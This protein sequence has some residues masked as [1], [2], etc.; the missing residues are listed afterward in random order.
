MDEH[1][2]RSGWMLLVVVGTMEAGVVG[3][4]GGS[5][6]AMFSFTM[7]RTPSQCREKGD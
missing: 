6:E 5:R 4:G 2:C 3:G 1:R 7:V